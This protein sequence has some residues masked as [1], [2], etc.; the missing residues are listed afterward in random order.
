MTN[1]TRIVLGDKVLAELLANKTVAILGKDR[2]LD[3]NIVITFG[4]PGSIEYD[5][6]TT[7][8]QQGQ[9]AT[10][11]CEGLIFKTNVIVKTFEDIE[12]PDEPIV[13]QP[14]L[15]STPIIYLYDEPEEPEEPD[16]PV[17][18]VELE[19]PFI[20]LEDIEEDDEEGDA[21][22]AVLGV[23]KLGQMV[24]GKEQEPIAVAY[25]LVPN[26]YGNTLILNIYT[27]EVTDDGTTVVV[28]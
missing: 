19:A 12:E 27:T 5:N 18:P 1:I 24:L 25:R 3:G 11:E 21:A 17:E 15:L 6:L 10:L 2:K 13:P 26:D 20:Y 8:I 22:C 16:I 14:T 9:T 7:T 28:G 23:G 4:I